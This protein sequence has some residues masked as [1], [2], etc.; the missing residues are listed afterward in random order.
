[1]A[2]CRE[3]RLATWSC[4]ACPDADVSGEREAARFTRTVLPVGTR[5]RALLALIW[6]STH[7]RNS[8]RH[9]HFL[10]SRFHI[11]TADLTTTFSRIYLS[12]TARNNKPRTSWSRKATGRMAH[13]PESVLRATV[14]RT[15]PRGFNDPQRSSGSKASRAVLRGRWE[16][17]WM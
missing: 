7:T 11:T 17:G 3:D 9:F 14:R 10:R 12:G 16:S 5:K 6:F 2:E 13:T 15:Q 8:H 1:M 4:L